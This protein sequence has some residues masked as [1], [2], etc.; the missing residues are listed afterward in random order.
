M[1]GVPSASIPLFPLNVVLFPGGALPL[2]LFEQRYLD[3]AKACLRVES[4]FGVCLIREGREVGA[5]AIPEAVGCTARI[6]QWDMQ[7]LGV[8]TVLA[9]GVQRFRV[10]SR[11]VEPNGLARAEVELLPADTDAPVPEELLPAAELL[12][13]AFQQFTHSE[14]AGA[15]GPVGAS[16]QSATERQAPEM[17]FDSCAW[18]SARLTEMLPLPLAVKQQL[19]EVPDGKTRLVRL[20]ALLNDSGLLGKAT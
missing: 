9:R 14:P 12:R 7:Q 20:A 5:P 3:M 2:R 10:L 4:V 19:L 16:G 13:N 15:S 8:L 18:V 11:T 1:S 17:R 6:E